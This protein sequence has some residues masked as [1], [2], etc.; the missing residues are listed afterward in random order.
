MVIEPHMCVFSHWA[1]LG[2]LLSLFCCAGG[3]NV[4]LHAQVTPSSEKIVGS[5]VTMAGVRQALL[6]RNRSG[7]TLR[8]GRKSDADSS[9]ITEG[10][11]W[12][13]E[14][15]TIFYPFD[16]KGL[17]DS[18]WDLVIIEGWF[19]MINSFIHEVRKVV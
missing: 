6:S 10:R 19:E 11:R 17:H 16:Y 7:N 13:V 4:A 9:S 3:I 8:Q 14:N 1:L 12:G 2:S 5:A 15:V 18:S